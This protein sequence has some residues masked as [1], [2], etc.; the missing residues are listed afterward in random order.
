MRSAATADEGAA[1]ARGLHT[2]MTA[3][4]DSKRAV[5]LLGEEVE[6]RPRENKAARVNGAGNQEPRE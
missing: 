5:S 6:I 3:L 1:F 2:R 4:R